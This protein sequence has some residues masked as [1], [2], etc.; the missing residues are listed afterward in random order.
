MVS[1]YLFSLVKG[2]EVVVFELIQELFSNI[3][4][5]LNK[6][7]IDNQITSQFLKEDSKSS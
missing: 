7:L 2:R 5:I 3:R 6:L 1:C 4:S